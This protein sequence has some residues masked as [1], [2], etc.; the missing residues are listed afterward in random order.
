MCRYIRKFSSCQGGRGEC[1][2]WERNIPGHTTG[3]T[4]YTRY[5]YKYS[6]WERNIPGHTTGSTK[7]TRYW[8]IYI[9]KVEGEKMY[10]R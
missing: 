5:W 6:V 4:K 2:V 8:Y 7:Y 1:S 9:N 3:S 10:K